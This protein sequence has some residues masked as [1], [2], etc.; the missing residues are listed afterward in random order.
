MTI[1]IRK[2]LPLLLLALVANASA[3]SATTHIAITADDLAQHN[4]SLV[5]ANSKFHGSGL[6]V[7]GRIQ[8]EPGAPQA[9]CGLL[10]LQVFDNSGTLLTSLT[11]SYTPCLLSYRPKVRRSGHFTASIPNLAPQPLDVKILFHKKSDRPALD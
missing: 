7:S 9:A 4:L 1:P 3:I 11:T 8:A 5:R 2:T 10:E 6:T